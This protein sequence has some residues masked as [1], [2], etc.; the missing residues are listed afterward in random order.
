MRME[1]GGKE[2]EF[3]GQP[4]TALTHGEM[5]LQHL[6]CTRDNVKVGMQNGWYEEGKI[7]EAQIAGMP[8]FEE[9]PPDPVV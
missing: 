5:M 6:R 8:E 7:S 1:F 2:K 3:G 9:R 4:H